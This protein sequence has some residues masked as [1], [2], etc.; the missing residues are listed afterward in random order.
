V[1]LDGKCAI[2]RDI[3]IEDGNCGLLDNLPIHENDQLFMYL[4]AILINTDISP[5]WIDSMYAVLKK[6]QSHC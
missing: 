5:F 4:M 3:Q 6:W 2:Y 1:I